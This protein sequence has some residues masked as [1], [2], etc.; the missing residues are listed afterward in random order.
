M[1]GGVIVAINLNDY[2][3]RT[4]ESAG[5]TPRHLVLSPDN[6]IL[7]VSNNLAG[8]VRAID[9]ISDTLLQ[10]VT[11]GTQPR[12]M[13]MS[14]DGLSLYVVNYRSDNL[15]KLRTSDM[16]IIQTIKTGHHPVGITYDA[17]MRRVWV[18][19]YSGTLSIF[20]DR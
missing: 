1:G 14:D 13:V 4:L 11:T 8:Q 3:T 17:E 18:A 10:S 2:S 19:N 16:Q 15:V 9:P 6:S 12:T 7:Y 20:E 5:Y